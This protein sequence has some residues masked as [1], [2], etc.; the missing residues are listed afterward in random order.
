MYSDAQTSAVLN[1]AVCYDI[2]MNNNKNLRGSVREE[3]ILRVSLQS[4][5]SNTY[6]RG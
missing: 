2:A 4:H 3:E 6:S 5:P 1:K